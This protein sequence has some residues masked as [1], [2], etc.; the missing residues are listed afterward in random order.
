MI[1]PLNKV[2][3][4]SVRLLLG[5]VVDQF[6]SMDG[7][8]EDESCRF[9]PL[10]STQEE[11]SQLAQSNSKSTQ[12]KDKWTVEVFRTW[13]AAREQ[14]FCILDPGS[15]FKDYYLHRVQSLEEKLEDLASLSL[16]YWLRKFVQ[17]VANK[18]EI[19]NSARGMFTEFRNAFESHF[20]RKCKQQTV[21]IIKLCLSCVFYEGHK[22]ISL[23]LLSATLFK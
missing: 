18:N 14:K 19:V 13:Q 12:Y 17:E 23:W 7:L 11:D 16:N 15:V 4:C 20:K 6:R 22:F 3:P 2:K 21:E 10:K 5:W 9:R 8:A 1:R